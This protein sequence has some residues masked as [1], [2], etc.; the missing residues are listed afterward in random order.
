MKCEGKT[1]YKTR[2]E[3]YR[4][5]TRYHY[6]GRTIRQY[7]YECPFCHYYHLSTKAMKWKSNAKSERLH[8][9]FYKQYKNL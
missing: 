6:R 2:A 3:A 7:V 5:S 4:Y 8:R 9:N 1:A